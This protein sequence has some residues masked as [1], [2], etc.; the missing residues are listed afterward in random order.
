MPAVDGFSVFAFR[1]P[2]TGKEGPEPAVF[3]HHWFAAF[4][5]VFDLGVVHDSFNN[6]NSA[7]FIPFIITGEGAFRISGTGKK[8]AVSAYFDFK[9]FST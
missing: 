2:G 7:L 3:L 6:G 9:G 8:M 5:A 4:Y 1:I